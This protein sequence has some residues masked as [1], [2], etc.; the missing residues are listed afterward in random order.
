MNTANAKLLSWSTACL[1]GAA[2][3]LYVGLFLT[4]FE[5]IKTPVS[6]DRL[7]SVLDNTPEIVAQAENIVPYDMV[8]SALIKFNWTGKAPPPPPEPT[9]V[10]A[11]PEPSKQGVAELVRI[12]GYKADAR[13][14]N[15]SVVVLEY[16]GAAQVPADRNASAG[17]AG[18]HVLAGAHLA[19]PI[20]HIRI[21]AV[22]MQGV[23][24]A[25]DDEER[26]HEFLMPGD[27]TLGGN[28]VQ[29]DPDHVR[30][31]PVGNFQAAPGGSY[32][33]SQTELI[34]GNRF[35]IGT[36]DSALIAADYSRILSEDV[37]LSAH[38]DPV[39]GRRDGVEIQTVRPNSVAARHG[40][41]SGDVI[42]SIN[43]TPVTSTQEA[44]SFVK[45]NQDAYE[46]W[47]VVVENMGQKRTVVYL[48]PVQ[49]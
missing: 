38:R 41:R 17:S 40:A 46:R 4:R 29:V 22:T 9:A 11:K 10:V 31:R 48:P 43:G 25:F 18:V 37:R 36:E 39:T 15:G 14:P 16:L 5:E 27:L 49:E 12:L 30:F 45:N 44:I 47:E 19:A 33:P 1:L 7:R 3:C 35:R 2:L 23:E 26:E 20:N 28:I 21:V 42:K 8:Q 6:V 32:R 24:F 34:G 13:D